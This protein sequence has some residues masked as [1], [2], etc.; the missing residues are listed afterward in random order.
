MS[1]RNG[2]CFFFKWC[3]NALFFNG[4]GIR[5][6]CTDQSIQFFFLGKIPGF[7]FSMPN[8]PKSFEHVCRLVSSP[9][10]HQWPT[11]LCRDTQVK[12]QLHLPCLQV[13][14]L[15]TCPQISVVGFLTN[16]SRLLLGHK[17]QN[18]QCDESRWLQKLCHVKHMHQ[19]YH[20][21]I[22]ALQGQVCSTGCF[23]TLVCMR[24]RRVVSHKCFHLLATRCVVSE[25]LL[26]QAALFGLALLTKPHT[27]ST[28]LRVV[29]GMWIDL[30]H[31]HCH[32]Q[33][34]KNLPDRFLRADTCAKGHTLPKFSTTLDGV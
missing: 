31:L 33:S 16:V 29:W 13:L 4:Q 21:E 11:F 3:I 34:G 1:S 8:F 7:A 15:S 6:T 10:N 9:N 19:S 2:P 28:V 12:S 32:G 23:P 25:R 30:G 14:P 5:A 20:A 27:R 26:I 22:G 17:H 24:L 18:H